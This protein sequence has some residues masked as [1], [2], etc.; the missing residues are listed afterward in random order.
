MRQPVTSKPDLIEIPVAE[1]KTLVRLRPGAQHLLRDLFHPDRAARL[2]RPGRGD[3]D[4]L[5]LGPGSKMWHTDPER[6]TNRV[7]VSGLFWHFVDLV[8]IFLFPVLYL[9]LNGL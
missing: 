2:A 3:R 5:P 1:I 9:T 6:F 4:C 8:W 7:E